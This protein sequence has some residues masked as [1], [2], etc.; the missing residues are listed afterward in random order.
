MGSIIVKHQRK[1]VMPRGQ[2]IYWVVSGIVRTFYSKAD[3]Y[4]GIAEALTVR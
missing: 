2:R 1:S 3:I 4:I